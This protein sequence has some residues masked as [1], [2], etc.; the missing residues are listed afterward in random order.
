MPAGKSALT[1]MKVLVSSSKG[2]SRTD[3]ATSASTLAGIS[4]WWGSPV[5]GSAVEQRSPFPE[6]TEELQN[7]QRVALACVQIQ[8]YGIRRHTSRFSFKNPYHLIVTKC[9]KPLSTE[10]S[11]RRTATSCQ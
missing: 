11:R 3:C 8:V 7:E 2:N 6:E 5:P 4:T 9:R 1:H 10:A